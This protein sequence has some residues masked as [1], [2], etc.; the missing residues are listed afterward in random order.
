MCTDQLF[1]W[2]SSEE[3]GVREWVRHVGLKKVQP[4]ASGWFISHLHPVLEDGHREL[5]TEF[6][7]Y[8]TWLLASLEHRGK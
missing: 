7:V 6:C 3:L 5:M 1:A 8:V 2:T 4:Q